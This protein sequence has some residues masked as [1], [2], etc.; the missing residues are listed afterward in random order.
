MA[1]IMLCTVRDIRGDYGYIMYEDTGITSEIALALVPFGI[2]IGYKL[3]FENYE[4]TV[5]T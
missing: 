3:I 1:Q 5:V 4:L 2:D